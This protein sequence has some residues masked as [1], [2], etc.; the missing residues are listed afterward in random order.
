MT[1]K[2]KL[3]KTTETRGPRHPPHS[4]GCCH[5]KTSHG[6]G[7]GQP[8]EVW[9][10][11]GRAPTR[12]RRGVWGGGSPPQGHSNEPRSALFK[13]PLSACQ[14]DPDMLCL[15]TVFGEA[16][17]TKALLPKAAKPKNHVL[18]ESVWLFVL[19]APG[20]KKIIWHTKTLRVVRNGFP[21]MIFLKATNS[22][23]PAL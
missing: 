9:W 1:N 2:M 22:A 21:T 5:P 12:M 6:A 13:R 4:G 19:G 3:S 14:R 18:L 20:L 10:G 15:P 8:G 16:W 11:G 17:G 7:G 23:L